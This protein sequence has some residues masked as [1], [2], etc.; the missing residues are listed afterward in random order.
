MFPQPNQLSYFS[1]DQ[2]LEESSQES[3][4]SSEKR[5]M[6]CGLDSSITFTIINIVRFIIIMSITSKLKKKRPLRKMRKINK[7]TELTRKKMTRAGECR[8]GGGEA[9]LVVRNEG[10]SSSTSLINNVVTFN[11]HSQGRS[12]PETQ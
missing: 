1:T 2:F 5:G 12:S 7:E 8:I 10:D 6:R 4:E 3:L 9:R 11:N